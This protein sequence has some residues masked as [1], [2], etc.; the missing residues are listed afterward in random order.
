M[1]HVDCVGTAPLLIQQKKGKK[2]FHVDIY[3]VIN[4]SHRITQDK[5]D[6]IPPPPH[7]H[8]QT[9]CAIFLAV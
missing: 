1:R 6:Y 4:S 5:G 8:T 7:A 2:T 3:V 9:G